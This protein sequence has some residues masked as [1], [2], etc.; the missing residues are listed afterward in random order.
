MAPT[1]PRR[2]PFS[3]RIVT[4]ST[5]TSGARQGNVKGSLWKP[6]GPPQVNVR[7]GGADEGQVREARG[8]IVRRP[9][10]II[11]TEGARLSAIRHKR[12][13]QIGHLHVPTVLPLEVLH[14][15]SLAPPARFA[16]DRPGHG[17]RTG[18]ARHRGA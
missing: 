15:V 1:S 2:N 12:H 17:P 4:A 3:S 13:K 5:G 14:V 7:G 6:K 8:S 11:D 16:D 10:S 18:L 9:T